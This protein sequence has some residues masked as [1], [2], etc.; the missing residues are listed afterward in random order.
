M[1]HLLDASAAGVYPIAPTPFTET[2]EIDWPSIEPMID[3]YLGCKVQGLTVLGLMGEAQ[4]L[5][6]SEAAELVRVVLRRVNGRI[7]VIVGVSSAGTAT[8]VALSRA[9]MAAGAC[10]VMIA[11]L[12]GLKT[13]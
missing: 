6:D 7:P 1:P 11:P 10:G 9:A 5:S 12:N 4:K 8:L 3:F 13:E 2:G